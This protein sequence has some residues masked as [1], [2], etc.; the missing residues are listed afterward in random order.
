MAEKKSS[1]HFAGRTH[2]K[3]G[4]A[5]IAAGAV[6]WV[7][8]VILCIA[9]AMAE[10]NA[11]LLAGWLGLLDMSLAGYGIYLAMKGLKERDVYYVLPFIGMTLNCILFVV[12]FSLYFTGLA[13]G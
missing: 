5:S 10:G 3:K 7:V 1:L 12:Y 4:A 13:I 2:S 6:A 11:G 9:S 8:F